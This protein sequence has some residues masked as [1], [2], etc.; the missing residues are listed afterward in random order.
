[1]EGEEIT[2]RQ[3]VR[4]QNEMLRRHI[5]GTNE[6]QTET[7]TCLA[8]IEVHNEYTKKTIDSHEKSING[9]KKTVWSAF[10]TGVVGIFHAAIA[11]FTK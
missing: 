9:I 2:L 11:F 1:M 8:K 6:F 4:E 10:G 3:L 7:K 5:D